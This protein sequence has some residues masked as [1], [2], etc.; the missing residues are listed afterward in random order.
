MESAEAA[1]QLA[2]IDLDNTEITAPVDGRLGEVSARLGQYVT[3]GTRVATIVPDKVWVVANFKETQ[4]RGMKVGQPVKFTVD[5]LGDAPLSGRIEDFSPA[6]GSE[7]SVLAASNATGNF[8]KIAQRIPVR[9][10]I[11]PDQ[12]LADSLAPG[13]SVVARID[14]IPAGPGTALAAGTGPSPYPRHR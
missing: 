4:V 13:M 10:A 2:R 3:A 11:D 14:T 8:I 5:A 9:I 6:T 12:P 1:V 7:F